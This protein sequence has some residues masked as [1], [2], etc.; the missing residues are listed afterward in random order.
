MTLFEYLAIAFG[1]LYSV[2]G[3]RLLGG[4]S[5][6]TAPGRRYPTHLTLV[7]V[8]LL[9]V[10]SSFWTFWSLRGVEWT[11]VGFLLALLVPGLLYYCAAVLVP[12]NPGEVASWRD[13][14][15]A[16]HRR[17]YAGFALWGLSAAAS[18]SVNLGMS[19]T[20]PARRVHV[21]VLVIGVIGWATSNPRVH[22]GL[23][24]TL[25]VLMIAG[26]VGINMAPGWLAHQ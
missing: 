3:L 8:M 15:F 24:A 9:L 7:V 10:A 5:V 17:L 22:A 23:A 4:L 18:A 25:V 1:L 11:F 21:A 13:Y 2:A 19:L 14:Y 6:A 16:G 12:E 20:H 26:A